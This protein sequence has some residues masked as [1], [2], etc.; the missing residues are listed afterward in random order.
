MEIVLNHCVVNTGK[1]NRLKSLL[2]CMAD[3]WWMKYFLQSAFIS[4][5]FP[6]DTFINVMTEE[7]HFTNMLM[8]HNSLPLWSN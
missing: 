2:C 5:V 7:I 1:T 3:T 8:Q 6:K 4:R